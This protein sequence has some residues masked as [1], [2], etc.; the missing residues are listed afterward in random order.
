MRTMHWVMAAA[1]LALGASF[2]TFA[3]DTKGPPVVRGERVVIEAAKIHGG[4]VTERDGALVTEAVRALD[5]D[6]L[7]NNAMV[8]VI[9][10]QGDLMV[11]GS[12]TDIAQSS[13]VVMK[14][15]SVPGVRKVYAFLDTMGGGDSN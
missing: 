8:S 15:K 10:N 3:Q 2:A 11:I 12:T 13:R 5:A 9:A 7:T 4:Y 14:L 6:R 1:S